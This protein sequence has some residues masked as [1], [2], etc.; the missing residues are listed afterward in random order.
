VMPDEFIPMA[1]HSGLMGSLTAYVID[2]SLAQVA[3][4]RAAGLEIPVAVN[5]SSRDLHGS[6]L[7]GVVGAALEQHGLPASMLALELTE[8]VLTRDSVEVADTLA[9]L[10]R[11]G[12]SIS[13]DDFGTGYSSMVLLKQ[14]PVAE[15]K[16]DRSFVSRLSTDQQ[17]V[18]IVRSIID[19]AHG[20]GMRAV[21]EGVETQEV[22]DLLDE[23]GCDAA[24]GWYVSRP[25]PGE[26]ASE[27]LLR[28][29]SHRRALHIV[30]S[31]AGIG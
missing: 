25:M 4:W 17:D 9:E 1:E 29:P 23:L 10:R 14:M 12:I 24:Q 26:A 6:E 7:V 5:V 22:W 31:Q 13:L 21:A 16:V 11:L 8:R 20:L 27:W 18:T 19:L 2:H 30:K 3:A 28:H 15:I